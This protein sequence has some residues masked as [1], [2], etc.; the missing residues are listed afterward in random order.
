MSAEKFPG[1]GGA[2]G[3]KTENSTIKS[4]KGGQPKKF[5]LKNS[6]IL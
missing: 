5:T 4:H 3:K 1:V 6:T 2:N